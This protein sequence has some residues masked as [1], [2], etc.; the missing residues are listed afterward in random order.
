MEERGGEAD[1]PG[2]LGDNAGGA[3]D[4]AEGGAD[5]FFAD[6]NDP[7]DKLEDV[8][9]VALAEGLRAEAVG[10]G[11]AGPGCW[12]LNECAGIEGLLGVGGELRLATEY[13]WGTSRQP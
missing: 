10:E 9:E 5:F 2:G 4:E 1:D 11:A 13:F 7:V 8:V 6:G 3:K 12:P